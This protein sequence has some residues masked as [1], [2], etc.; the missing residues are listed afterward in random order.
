MQMGSTQK[1]CI[2]HFKGTKAY[3]V[4]LASSTCSFSLVFL[5]GVWDRPPKM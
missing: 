3:I 1:Q 2:T 4:K 5:H